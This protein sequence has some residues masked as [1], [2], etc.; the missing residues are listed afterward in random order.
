MEKLSVPLSDTNESLLTNPDPLA[1]KDGQPGVVFRWMEAEGPIYEQWPQPGHKLLFGELPMVNRP[2]AEAEPDPEA[3]ASATNKFGM[4]RFRKAPGVEVI[5]KKPMADAERLLR[6]F[7]RQAYRRPVEAAEVKRFLPVVQSALKLG[8]NFTDA[9][10]AGY[11]A[12]LCSPGFIYLD[13]KP[14][15][16]DDYELASRLAFFLWNSPPDQ[17]LRRRAKQQD[18][19][20][21]DVLRAQ[22]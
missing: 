6:G 2:A 20:E 7:I 3:D 15:R 17:E 9:M 21:P 11:T 13:E 1:E 19:H 12:V 22:T 4:R 5:S 8:N 16:L 18:L 14:G 10:I